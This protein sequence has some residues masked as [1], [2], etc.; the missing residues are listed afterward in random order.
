MKNNTTILFAAIASLLFTTADAQIAEGDDGNTA[1]VELPTRDVSRGD[2]ELRDDLNEKMKVL[3][4]AGKLSA[5][6]ALPWI[7]RHAFPE[8]DRQLSTELTGPDLY[9][10]VGDATVMFHTSYKCSHCDEWHGGVA[11][12]FIIHPDGWIVTAAHVVADLEDTDFATVMTRSEEVFPL[13]GIFAIDEDR[14]VAILKV[15]AEN[16]T[17]LPLAATNPRPGTPIHVL[18]HPQ[19]HFFLLTKGI[20]SRVLGDEAAAS[21][22]LQVTAEFATGSSGGP[23]V[24]QRGNLVGVVSSTITLYADKEEREDPQLVIRNCVAVEEIHDILPPQ[25]I[26]NKV[27]TKSRD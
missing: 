12:G 7:P 3:E 16:L 20:V 5:F 1:T 22:R 18:S 2:R 9:D 11:T 27:E 21:E 26:S 24:D 6:T 17:A 4:N 10:A 13:A 25:A 19:G 23:V 14:D 8:L 15:D